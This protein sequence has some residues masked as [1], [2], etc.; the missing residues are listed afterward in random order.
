MD[1][2]K[3]SD[4]IE[5]NPG[6]SNIPIWLRF[7]PAS[8]STENDGAVPYGST[9]QSYSVTAK[10]IEDNTASTALIESVSASSYSVLVY[11]NHTTTLAAGNYFLRATV[12]H[13][14]SGS[15]ANLMTRSYDLDRIILKRT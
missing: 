5:I 13:A 9:M 6:S 15:T 4:H 7:I 2:F 14:L 3:G 10:S 11:L 8:E 12:V 1:S